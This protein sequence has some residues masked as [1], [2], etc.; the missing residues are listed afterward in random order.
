MYHHYCIRNQPISTGLCTI[1]RADTT[2]PSVPVFVPSPEQTQPTH[3]YRSFGGGDGVVLLQEDRGL[4]FVDDVYVEG[5][6]VVVL[7][8]RHGEVHSV[9][10][11]AVLELLPVDREPRRGPEFP[12]CEQVHPL[13]SVH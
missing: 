11:V 10:V 6:L 13:M 4:V 8:V 9:L 1:T 7:A 2:N 3:Q 5:L 12:S